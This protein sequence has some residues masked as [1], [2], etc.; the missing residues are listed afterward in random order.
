MRLT[1]SQQLDHAEMGFCTLSLKKKIFLQIKYCEFNTG[2][3]SRPTQ[4][5]WCC[6]SVPSN[7]NTK[8]NLLQQIAVVVY[9]PGNIL[10]I[11]PKK[12]WVKYDLDENLAMLSM[13]VDGIHVVTP[14]EHSLIQHVPSNMEKYQDYSLFSNISRKSR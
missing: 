14:T 7:S 6:E 2:N 9:R 3:G 5:L 12:D 11:S 4:L 1:H 13:D 10:L 8:S